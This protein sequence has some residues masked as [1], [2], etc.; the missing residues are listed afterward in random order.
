MGG[1]QGEVQT[2]ETGNEF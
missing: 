1:N 2:D